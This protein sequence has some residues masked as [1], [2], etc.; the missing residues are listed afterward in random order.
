MRACS[1][2][3]P[4]G[5]PIGH[6][7]ASRPPRANPIPGARRRLALA[8]AQRDRSHFSRSRIRVKSRHPGMDGHPSRFP[9]AEASLLRWFA[10]LPIE[11]KLRLVITFPALTAFAIALACMS[12]HL[13][14]MR[15]ECRA[16]PC[17]LRAAPAW[18]SSKR[19]KRRSRR[20]AQGAQRSA[21]RELRG[22]RGD[23]RFRTAASSPAIVA[24]RRHRARADRSRRGRA[25]LRLP[26]PPIP[27]SGRFCI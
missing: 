6:N 17:G 27:A 26:Q 25:V 14:H 22:R 16:A 2:T 5:K 1:S 19:L 13:V 8:W 23:S 4:V 9:H 3:R 15:E 18:R 7:V 11:R 21:Q 12:R 10:D 24:V 20:R